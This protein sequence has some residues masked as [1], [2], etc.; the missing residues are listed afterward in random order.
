MTLP[1]VPLFL[2]AQPDQQ[3]QFLH[4]LLF[5]LVIHRFLEVL[6]FHH[7]RQDLVGLAVLVLQVHPN[8]QVLWISYWI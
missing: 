4:Y 8:L 7:F 6:V 3:R 5:R 1:W 2:E